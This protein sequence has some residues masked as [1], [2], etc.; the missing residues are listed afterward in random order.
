M[1]TL[2]P[3]HKYQLTNFEDKNSFQV[4][5]F[6]EKTP[7]AEGST[8]LKTVNDGT[9]NEEL[10]EVLLD[11]LNYLQAKF[12]CRENALAITN[13]EQA[14]MWLNRRTANRVKRGVEGTMQK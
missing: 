7:V 3:G 8:E 2:T 11:R 9:T 5:Q 13:A 4:I 10:L 1:E 6:I 14:L 12:P